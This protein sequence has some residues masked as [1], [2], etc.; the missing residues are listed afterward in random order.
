VLRKRIKAVAAVIWSGGFALCAL[1]GCAH[2]H[3][4]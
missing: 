3:F 4:V 2:H 1:S